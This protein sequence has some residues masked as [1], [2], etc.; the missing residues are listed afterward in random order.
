VEAHNERFSSTDSINI[1]P[2]NTQTL[3][4]FS[5]VAPQ[6]VMRIGETQVFA[7]IKKFGYIGIPIYSWKLYREDILYLTGS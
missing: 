6:E 3:P 5:I 1:F 4:Y 2:L 7:S